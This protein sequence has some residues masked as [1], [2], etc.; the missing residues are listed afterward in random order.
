[1]TEQMRAPQEDC[2]LPARECPLLRTCP[3]CGYRFL[4]ERGRIRHQNNCPST[5]DIS[6]VEAQHLHKTLHHQPPRQ[7]RRT[8]RDSQ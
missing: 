6:V 1:M 3:C 8:R 5:I 4:S 2:G 7:R